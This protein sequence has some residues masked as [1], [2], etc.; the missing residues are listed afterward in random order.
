MN[1]EAVDKF[2]KQLETE[3]QLKTAQYLKEINYRQNLIDE[4]DELIKKLNFEKTLVMD[5]LVKLIQDLNSSEVS[6]IWG[7]TSQYFH[8]A[9][10]YHNSKN[11]IKDKE[12]KEKLKQSY[13]YV[14]A[15]ITFVIL[16]N[17][18]DFKLQ[19]IVT[20]GYDGYQYAFE[21]KYKKQMFEIV[22]PM[23]DNTTNENYKEILAG[24]KVFIQTSESCWTLIIKDLDPNVVAQKLKEYIEGDKDEH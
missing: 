18:K 3:R 5:N 14:I 10:R 11:E 17:N 7:A 6:L 12:K 16:L 1:K 23:F 2:T 13:G 20:Y 22:I 4:K 19:K 9:W 15:R 21:Y 24:Y 8:D